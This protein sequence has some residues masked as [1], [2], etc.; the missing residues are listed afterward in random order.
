[1]R[2][3]R[4]YLPIPRQQLTFLYAALRV[5]SFSI[6]IMLSIPA[7]ATTASTA[8]TTTTG[9]CVNQT[10]TKQAFFGDLH[11]HT[12]ISADAMLFGT[13]THPDDAY[14]FATGKPI[15]IFRTATS[16]DKAISVQLA[17][18]LDFAAVTDHAENIGAVTLCLDPNSSA[19]DT[20]S[21][22]FVR[23]PLPSDSLANFAEKLA[24]QFQTMYSSKE[25]CGEDKQRC[26]DAM[27]KPWAE[28]QQAALEWNQP[29]EFSTF[30][31]YEYSPTDRGSNLHHNVLFRTAEVMS[32]P[33]SMSDVPNP[34]ELYRRLQEECNESNTGCRAIAIPHNSNI[35]NGKILRLDYP[36]AKTDDERKKLAQL[37][38]D[39]IPIVE[40]FQE[41]GDSECRNGLW[42]VFGKPDEYCNFEKFRDWQGAQH[43]DCQTDTGNGGFQNQG[44]VSRLDYTRYALAAGI[45]EK[46]RLGVNSL[47]FG[48]IG[49]TDNHFGTAGDLEESDHNGRDRPYSLIEP[50]RMS[51]GGMAGIWARENT[52]EA[53]FDAMEQR[54]VFATSGPRIKPRLFAG[55]DINSSSCD[56][57]KMIEKSYQH[58]VPMGGELNSDGRLQSPIFLVSALAD[59]GT[60]LHSGT[61]L[62]R[63]QIIKAWPG[64]NNELHQA[65]YDI[66]IAEGSE[67]ASVDVD[68]CERKGSGATALCATWKDPDYDASVNAVYYARVLENPSCRHTGYSCMPGSANPLPDFC[69]DDSIPKHIQERAWTSAIWVNGTRAKSEIVSEKN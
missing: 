43:E 12:G 31:G 60:L 47:Q 16:M 7:A 21:C 37:R 34:F 52:R 67:S 46:A 15:D 5:A 44:C 61:P 62:Q 50:G 14:S 27:Q 57:P 24:R 39:I 11:I 38:R 20:K 65:I 48:V 54:E 32:A 49:A 13:R 45:A 51:T 3:Y 17:R 30:V 23:E 53:L 55:W 4:R 29:C 42:N 58:G 18:P 59:P 10:A 2:R 22:Q 68:N 64:K 8:T 40:I 63:L 26:T 6:I 66:A 19:Y 56:D 1:M 9:P 36:N 41:K 33:I 69:D 35:S 28:I 25:I